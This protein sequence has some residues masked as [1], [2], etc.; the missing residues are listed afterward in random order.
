MEF[1][2]KEYGITFVD[3]K[4]GKTRQEMILEQESNKNYSNCIWDAKGGEYNH[5]DDIVCV[6]T[7]SKHVSDHVTV[8]MKCCFWEKITEK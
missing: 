2:E 3:H 8:D 7:D 1:F 4:T 5:P 6:N